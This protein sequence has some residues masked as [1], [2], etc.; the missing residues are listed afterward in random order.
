[1]PV[2]AALVA[3]GER[4]C[5]VRVAGVLAGCRTDGANRAAA[6]VASAPT[7]VYAAAAA[8]APASAAPTATPAAAP[9]SAP[10]PGRRGVVPGVERGGGGGDDVVFSAPAPVEG[11]LGVSRSPAPADRGGRRG[12]E[13]PG[14][15]RLVRILAPEGP[16][17]AE[18]LHSFLLGVGRCRL[19]GLAKTVDEPVGRELGLV[20]V[21]GQFVSDFQVGHHCQLAG[22]RGRLHCQLLALDERVVYLAVQGDQRRQRDVGGLP[23][24]PRLGVQFPVGVFELYMVVRWVQWGRGCTCV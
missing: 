22:E 6:V 20:Q 10:A 13:L 7:A 24:R 17:V 18:L 4:A 5:R 15:Q 21:Y 9:S 12:G 14:G 11:G 3:R 19:A 2:Q 23:E 8:A 1:M 16:L